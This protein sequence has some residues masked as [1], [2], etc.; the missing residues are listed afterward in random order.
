MTDNTETSQEQPQVESTETLEDL[1][2]EFKV[3]ETPPP[4]STPQQVQVNPQDTPSMPDPVTDQDQFKDWASRQYR[5][6]AALRSEV[7]ETKNL[8]NTEREKLVTE[9][10]EKDFRSV[11]EEIAKS[12]SIDADDAEAGLLHKFFK[13][14]AFQH[15]WQNRR[16]NPGAFK[17]VKSI[18]SQEMKGRFSAKVDSQIAENQ[19]AV[20]EATKGVSVRK[21]DELT[22]DD[23]IAKMSDSEFGEYWDKEIHSGS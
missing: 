8:L 3:Q 19:R 4:Q 1:Y 16:S 11:A 13:D 5:E 2:G 17:K 12:V 6:V 14:T 15:V 20:E 10:E 9:A 22:T 23:K 18:L 21:T 7:S